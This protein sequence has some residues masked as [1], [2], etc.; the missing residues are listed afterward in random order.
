M[1][2]GRAL[3]PLA[4]VLLLLLSTWSGWLAPGEEASVVDAERWAPTFF[5]LQPDTYHTLA[6]TYALDSSLDDRSPFADSRLG[7]FSDEG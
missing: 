4:L 5:E 6:G 7:R 2:N 1:T 3:R